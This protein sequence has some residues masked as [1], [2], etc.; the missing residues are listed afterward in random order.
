[1]IF[2]L[3]PFLC[4]YGILHKFVPLLYAIFVFV[5]MCLELQVFKSYH[6]K[7]RK[8]M[9]RFELPTHLNQIKN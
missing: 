8:S 6:L 1:M 5:R 4:I 9:I 7:I 2:G 3:I